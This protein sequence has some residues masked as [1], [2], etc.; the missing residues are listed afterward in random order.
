MLEGG[1]VT[2]E[3]TYTIQGDTFD[4]AQLSFNNRPVP[5]VQINTDSV[6]IRAP[7]V[8]RVAANGTET[9]ATITLFALIRTDTS[10]YTFAVLGK[11]LGD[12]DS[13]AMELV[14]QCKLREY[15]S[16]SLTFIEETSNFKV[17]E[18]FQLQFCLCCLN[19]MQISDYVFPG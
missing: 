6:T 3:W 17:L 16:S 1:S 7:F 4:Q 14:V 2:L 8:G 9:N 19:C 13:A 18:N 11:T 12:F 5:F 10:T 15:L